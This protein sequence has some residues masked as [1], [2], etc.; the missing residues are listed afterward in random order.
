MKTLTK[1]V[2]VAGA[3]GVVGR[4]AAEHFRL[5]CNVF[6]RNWHA[7]KATSLGFAPIEEHR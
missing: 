3:Q 7:T 2:L 1:T 5:K 4:T 6:A